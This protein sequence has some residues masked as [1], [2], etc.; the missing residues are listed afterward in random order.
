[1]KPIKT[2]HTNLTLGAPQGWDASA[3][4]PCEGLPILRQSED[5]LTTNYSYWRAEW[6]ERIAVLFGRPIRLCVVG[7]AHPPVHLDTEKL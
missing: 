5:G 7:Q 6:K 1:M 2:E 3:N 4:G